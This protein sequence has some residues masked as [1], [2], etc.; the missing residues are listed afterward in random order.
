M[1]CAS[2]ILRIEPTSLFYFSTLR[3]NSVI[4]RDGDRSGCYDAD[5]RRHR[6]RHAAHSTRTSGSWTTTRANCDDYDHYEKIRRKST[7]QCSFFSFLGGGEKNRKNKK[8]NICRIERNEFIAR[9]QRIWSFEIFCFDLAKIFILVMKNFYSH[10]IFLSLSL[11]NHSW[12][13]YKKE[14]IIFP[15]SPEPTLRLPP[16]TPVWP[17]VSFLCYRAINRLWRKDAVPASITV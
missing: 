16:N 10:P 17:A 6:G 13:T 11:S 8:I 12:K 9:V 7:G 3:W 1:Q 5:R 15:D 2:S 4:S 14:K